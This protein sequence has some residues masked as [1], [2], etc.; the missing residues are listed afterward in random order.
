MKLFLC[1]KP[2]QGNDIAKV[3]GC[4]KRGDGFLSNNDDSVC[5]TWAVGH[6][7]EQFSPE[8]YDPAWKHWALETLPILPSSW[9]LSP[10]NNTKKQYNAVMALLKKADSVVIATDIDREG[11]M[12]ARELLDLAKFKGNIARLWLS[13]LDE[14]SIRKALQSL[15]AGNETINLYY[16]GLARSRA[17]WLVGMNFSRLFTLL[18][19]QKGFNG[20]MSVGRV[21]SPTL[22]LVVER[23][24][25][26]KNF[27]PLNHYKLLATLSNSQGRNFSATL[28]IPEHFLNADGLCLESSLLENITTKVQANGMMK[29]VAVETKR[30]KE[31]PPLPFNLSTLQADCNRL[32]GFGATEVLEIAQSLYESHKATTYPRSDCPYLPTEQ[33]AEVPKVISAILGSDVALASIKNHLNLTQISRAWNDK[34]ITAHHAII[35]TMKTVDISKMNDKELKV[36]DLIRRHYLAQFLSSAETDK[37]EVLLDC[38]SYQFK[39]AGNVEIHAGWKMLFLKK[40][41]ESK[42][43]VD[44]EENSQVLPK[45]ALNEQ[46][47]ILGLNLKHLTTN[48]PPHFTEGT[49]LTAMVNAARF[50]KDTRLKQKLKETEGLG[51]EATRAALIQNLLDKKFLTKKGKSIIATAEG[52][53]L[54][55][56]L[57]EVLKDPGMTALWEQALNQIANCELSLASFMEKQ[58]NF[59]KMIIQKVSNQGISLGDIKVKK[60]RSCGRVMQKRTGKFGQF[61]GCTGYPECTEIENI[62]VT[63][64]KP[65][66]NRK[67]GNEVTI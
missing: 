24:R 31:N 16:A 2:S 20:V 5:V 4:S 15:K 64:K 56:N 67:N 12:I 37:T 25:Q 21:Q 38:G 22:N 65:K 7:V 1:E 53:A 63:S 8:K 59:I 61:W 55:D 13:A 49:L 62:A 36:Y 57:P 11:E 35:P 3:L 34:K 66:K 47:Q 39:T 33:L 54:I 26:I 52:I 45:I 58:E 18:A 14:A 50:V 40:T 27:I 6:L 29:A 48:P 44:A 9:K 46:C 42:S 17:D 60:C 41:N 30:V 43:D 51:T 32:F 19:K 28:V 23:D 10:K